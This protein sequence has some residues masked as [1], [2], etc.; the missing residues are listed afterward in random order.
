M[1]K[2]KTQRRI[3]RLTRPNC[4]NNNTEPNYY[5]LFEAFCQ[6]PKY[7]LLAHRGEGEWISELWN[8]QQAGHYQAT[9]AS[10]QT[11]GKE[12]GSAKAR[13]KHEAYKTS[14]G[15]SRWTKATVSTMAMNTRGK[16]RRETLNK[17]MCAKSTRKAQERRKGGQTITLR[18]KRTAG[19][20]TSM[21][22][23]A[24]K[25]EGQPINMRTH[26]G[27]HRRRHNVEGAKS[28]ATA[29]PSPK[30]WEAGK[31]PHSRNGCGAGTCVCR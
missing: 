23:R 25:A 13:C 20:A 15:P 27:K 12:E 30:G 7:H 5:F 16:K 19:P 11:S 3:R 10:V 29:N 22:H 8:A 26:P 14:S 18:P 17:P 6:T 1:Q 2:I 21:A 9:P 4:A 24:R 31:T 28:S